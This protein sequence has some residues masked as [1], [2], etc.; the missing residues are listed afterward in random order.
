MRSGML[1]RN[2]C[3]LYWS[4]RYLERAEH[5]CR[6]L[7]IQMKALSDRSAEAVSR[8][9]QRLYGGI[10]RVPM[11]GTTKF[12]EPD[13]TFV[14]PDSYTLTDE[15]TFE[16]LNPDSIRSC[17]GRARENLRQVRNSVS[18]EMWGSLN[19]AYLDLV[20]HRIENLWNLDM[21][22][23]YDNTENAIREF[24][25]AADGAMYRD[26]GWSF[27]HLGR[28]IERAQLLALL[29]TSHLRL[30]PSDNSQNE[31]DW[32]SLLRACHARHAFQRLNALNHEAH[33]VLDF[34]VSNHRVSHSLRYTLGRIGKE[35]EEVSASEPTPPAQSAL[36]RAGSAMGRIDYDWP[37]RNPGDDEEALR[38]LEEILDRCHELHEDINRAYFDYAIEDAPIS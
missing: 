37:Q 21:S 9:W 18:P 26:E 27:L 20:P 29:F 35:L 38:V 10:R 36:R 25:G 6:L 33:D 16:T 11:V 1:S 12:E 22:G 4:G 13:D 31:L 24:F 15:L 30:Y 7:E 8:N 5:L 19:R 34:L 2:A 3:G 23:F 17:I 14:L 32:E 28:F